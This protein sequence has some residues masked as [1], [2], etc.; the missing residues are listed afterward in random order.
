M[1]STDITPGK[2]LSCLSRKNAG[3]KTTAATN[4]R[5]P[6]RAPYKMHSFVPVDLL[7]LEGDEKG[8]IFYE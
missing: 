7:P 6:K 2:N 3:K 1:I 5:A 4:K 8:E